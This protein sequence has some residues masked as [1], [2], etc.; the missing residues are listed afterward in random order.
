[1]P[2][3]IQLSC[4]PITLGG[5]NKDHDISKLELFSYNMLTGYPQELWKTIGTLGFVRFL[6]LLLCLCM[7]GACT[8]AKAVKKEVPK[9]ATMVIVDESLVS[10]SE[11]EVRKK[12]GNPTMVS[13]TAEDH[14]LWTYSPTWKLMP[15][16]SGT[17][18]VEFENGKATKIIRVR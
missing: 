14:I 1:V 16:N 17:I 9:K 13:R 12:L 4:N 6:A 8:S 5:S 7:V 2:D 10:S 15:N 11:E 3:N 18:Y